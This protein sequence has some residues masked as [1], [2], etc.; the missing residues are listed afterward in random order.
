MKLA[1]LVEDTYWEEDEPWE[2][3]FKMVLEKPDR[4]KTYK[5]IVWDYIEDEDRD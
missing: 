2:Y 3:R 1:Y 4:Y 5:T